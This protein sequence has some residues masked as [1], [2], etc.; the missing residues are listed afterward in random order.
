MCGLGGQD[1]TFEA[2]EA[3]ENDGGIPD[4]NR[5]QMLPKMDDMVDDYSHMME[6]EEDTPEQDDFREHGI[7]ESEVF[8]HTDYRKDDNSNDSGDIEEDLEIH[9]ATDDDWDT[10]SF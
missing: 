7:F 10:N 5:R 9:E 3:A 4:F 1:F 2:E 6:E 8:D